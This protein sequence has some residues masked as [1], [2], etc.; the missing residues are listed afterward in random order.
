MVL[1]V[2]LARSDP[3]FAS[4]AI[5]EESGT[6]RKTTDISVV[7]LMQTSGNWRVVLGPGTAFAEICGRPTV[8]AVRDL[9]CPNPYVVLGV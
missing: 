1:S 4:A 7:V 9:L 8:N 2:R 5:V 3:H 6:G